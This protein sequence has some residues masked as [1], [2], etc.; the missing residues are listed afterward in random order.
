M[1]RDYRVTRQVVQNQARPK[2]SGIFALKATGGFAQPDA[3]PCGLPE[4]LWTEKE[5]PQDI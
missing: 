4:I 1:R 3:S 2:E 5:H